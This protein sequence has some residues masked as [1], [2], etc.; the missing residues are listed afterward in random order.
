MLPSFASRLM[1][2][3]LKLTQANAVFRSPEK[4]REH[5]AK[6]SIRPSSYGPPSLLR[7]DVSVSVDHAQGWPVYTL[8]PK[9]GRVVGGAVYLHGGG[10]VN[11]IALQHWQLAAQIAAEAKVAVTVPIYP[12]VP[13][14]TAEEVIRKVVELV[15]NSVALYGET[16]LGGDSAGGE[17]AL[18][19]AV[20]L[21][22]EHE[23]VLPQTVLIAPALDLSLKNPQIDVVLRTDPWLGR[24]GTQV[25][26]EQWRGERSVE[27]PLVSPL[28][29]ELSG[30]GPLTIFCGTRDMVHP[31]T[32][33]L[34]DKAS[35]ADVVV[36]F[37]EGDGLVH[38]YPLTPTPEGRAA[39]KIIVE[40]FGTATERP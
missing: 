23:M 28:N 21:R 13:F 30:I 38:V 3:F 39:R 25:F 40:R 33:L 20:L 6:R 27:D 29:A 36:E 14:G 15:L 9:T 32:R 5:M 7:R 17:I 37:H 4:A 8:T 35:R 2:V 1:P 22:D 11:E 31:D 24:E 12:L 26:I 34:V 10:W 16:T 19:A 18:S